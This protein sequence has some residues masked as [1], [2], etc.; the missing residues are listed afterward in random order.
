MKLDLCSSLDSM[1]IAIFPGCF[2]IVL[3]SLALLF[4]TEKTDG[5]KVLLIGPN[6]FLPQ[7]YFKH[8]SVKKVPNS[9]FFQKN[10]LDAGFPC[11]A[12]TRENGSAASEENQS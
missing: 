9:K 5:E 4:L 2:S 1:I 12:V 3:S 6:T 11:C 7:R 8:Q 10:R